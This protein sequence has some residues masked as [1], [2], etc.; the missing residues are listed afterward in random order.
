MP[1]GRPPKSLR[2]RQQE[3]DL[4]KNGAKKLQALIDAEPK[5]QTG[6]GGCPDH[7]TGLAREAWDRWSEQLHIMDLDRRPD[8]EMLEGACVAYQR[9]VMADEQI[10]R[11]GITIKTYKE[12]EGEMYLT[13]C[14]KHPA[15][16]ISEAAW[17]QVAMFCRDF[18]FSPASRSRL[19]VQKQEKP[20]DLR[21]LLMAPDAKEA[22]Q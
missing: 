5:T 16:T 12:V 22:I 3:G 4:R 15:I 9:A 10:K 20:L 17:R 2:Q 13:S 1:A 6:L 8:A 19:A 18:G 14:R 21:A 11:E 7:L